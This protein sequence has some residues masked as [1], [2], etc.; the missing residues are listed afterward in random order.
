MVSADGLKTW[1]DYQLLFLGLAIAFVLVASAGSRL[2]R[3]LGRSRS[4][5]QA[6][7]PQPRRSR[8]QSREVVSS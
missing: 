4:R 7:S 6:S 3:Y 5:T 2:L 1:F 8:S